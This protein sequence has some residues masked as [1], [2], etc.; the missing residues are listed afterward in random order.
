MD[1]I[2][3]P[4][5]KGGLGNQMFQIAAAKAHAIKH[6]GFAAI[7]Y[8]RNGS[9]RPGNEL[10]KYRS[11]FYSKVGVTDEVVLTTYIEPHF[12]FSEIPFNGSTV[13]DGYFQSIKYFDHCK[14]IIKELFHFTNADKIGWR[15]LAGTTATNMV[16]PLVVHVRRGDY[17]MYPN[18]HPTQSEEYYRN[19]FTYF[20]D[21]P[22]KPSC[23]IICTD[24]WESLYQDNLIGKVF[25][26]K[27]MPVY[28]TSACTEL[29]DLYIMSQCKNIIMSNSSFSW[30]GEFLGADKI[31]VAPKKWLGY[32]GPQD[33]YDIYN[34][35]WQLI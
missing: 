34:P 21:K 6:N 32:D 19:A 23:V 28:T 2:I 17:K 9:S 14:D 29:Q 10:S 31:T 15:Q 4:N 13:I 35:N 22:V 20:L 8:R 24:D 1:N 18:I 25:T 30:W 27:G 11:N 5:L 3:I 7:N 33:Y 16:N 12:H 26:N